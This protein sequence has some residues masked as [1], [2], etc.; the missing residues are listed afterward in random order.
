MK[1]KPSVLFVFV[2]TSQVLR[3]R[4]DLRLATANLAGFLKVALSASITQ[5]VLAVEF[6]LHAAQRSVGRLAFT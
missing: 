5:D 2:L 4:G 1:G 3:E 6:A